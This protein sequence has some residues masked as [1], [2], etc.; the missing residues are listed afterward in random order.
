VP[1]WALT[2]A[3]SYT[4]IPHA[5]HMMALEAPEAFA[6]VLIEVCDSHDA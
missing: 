2:A 6:G 5:G 4:E 1:E 3:A